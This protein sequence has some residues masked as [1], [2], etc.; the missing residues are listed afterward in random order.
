MG[1]VAAKQE[2]RRKKKM[3][4]ELR[5]IF[6]SMDT[7]GSGMLDLQELHSAPDDVLQKVV[8]GAGGSDIRDIDQ[9]WQALDDDGSG[10]VQIEEFC[11]Y[12]M[13]AQD[14]KS[15]EMLCIMKRCGDLVHRSNKALD[16]L[17]AVHG[18]KTPQA[19]ADETPQTSH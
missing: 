3:I 13:K 18:V 1:E 2:A 7:D 12:M 8:Q 9:I 10:T 4:V 6:E 17:K 14:G 19:S 15:M 16:I 11:D 5:K